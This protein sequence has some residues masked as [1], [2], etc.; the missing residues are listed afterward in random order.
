MFKQNK[1]NIHQLIPK[2]NQINKK[3]KV[4]KITI[5]DTVTDN[6]YKAY[7]SKTQKLMT[8]AR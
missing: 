4:T 8:K 7:H 1:K 5:E 3:T 2:S 6:I